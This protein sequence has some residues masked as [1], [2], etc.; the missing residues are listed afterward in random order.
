[1]GGS[2]FEVAVP[3]TPDVR[4]LVGRESECALLSDAL[5]H[6]VS[7][8]GSALLLRGQAGM[9]KTA[10][11]EWAVARA[12]VR[13]MRVLRM[14][15]APAEA[16]LA[17]A[18][19][20]QVLWPLL[21]GTTGLP[22]AQRDALERALGVREGAQ[23]DGFAV[24]DAT[25]GLLSRAAAHRPLLV[26]LDDLHCCDT[27][28]ATVFGSLQDRVTELPV[29]LLAATRPEGM[30]VEAAVGSDIVDVPRL[31]D[32]QA[33]LLVE[34]HRPGLEESAVE[35]ILCEAQGN[36]LALIELPRQLDRVSHRGLLPL[37]APLP[38]GE[39]L[40]DVFGSRINTLSRAARHLLLLTALGTESGHDHV[41]AGEPDPAADAAGDG[42]PQRE[43]VESGL[44]DTHPVTGRPRLRHPLIGS[45]AVH[46]APPS[47]VREAHL[48]LAGALPED[49][50]RHALHLAAGT[51]GADETVALRL[52][53]AAQAMA[54]R[55]GDIEAAR[56][57]ARAAALSEDPGAAATRRIM[58]AS[59][60][61][62]GSAAL[63]HLRHLMAEVARHPVPAELAPIHRF[64]I[65]FFQLHEGSDL[66]TPASLM[67]GILDGLDA[68]PR[69]EEAL[70]GL[71]DYLYCLLILVAVYTGDEDIWDALDRH[72]HL[73]SPLARLCHDVWKDPARTAHGAGDRLRDLLAGLTPEQEAQSVWLILWTAVGLNAV[74]EHP[75]VLERLGRQ[76]VWGTRAFVNLVTCRDDVLAGRWDNALRSA[77]RGARESVARGFELHEMTHHLHTG[78]ILAAR[79]DEAALDAL[80]ERLGPWARKR[81]LRFLTD[82]MHAH[83]SLLALGA[84]DYEEAYAHAA[85]VTPA[86]RLP[87]RVPWFQHA[88]LDLVQAAIHTGRHAQAR[89]HVDAAVAAEI[90]LISAHHSFVLAVARAV[91]SQDEACFRAALAHPGSDRWPMEKAR[92]HL[93]Y[94]AQLRRGGHRKAAAAPLLVA[95]RTFT[96]LGAALWAA[97]AARELRTVGHDPH[98][99]T[100]RPDAW[101]HLTAQERRIT[102]LAAAGLTNREIGNRLRL[103]PRTVGAHLYKAF[104][105]LGVTSRAALSHALRGGEDSG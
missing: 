66:R 95:H 68:A 31:T 17:Y 28:S 51:I 48:E 99:T 64:S 78:F 35:R 88:F 80:H 41:L 90:H 54:L 10:L 67:A 21:D 6:A 71:W 38:V 15:G 57:Y 74:G 25:L 14:A 26:V 69:P 11:L 91:E 24:G 105:K 2:G 101:H 36:P 32:E 5:D 62:R 37:G 46:L 86:G 63:E 59:L 58:A 39:R 19:L 93:A 3:G 1:M 34:A 102:E 82:G 60:A 13:R 18:A 98:R 42:H 100:P 7:G 70:A 96:A 8:T 84:Q 29:V 65:A 44:A 76:D 49:H 9:G 97:A 94:G 83:R 85:A 87:A 53:R 72:I 4:A 27:T 45:C 16:D 103:S 47:A 75:A 73:A 40:A 55:R 77:E 33:R 92:L 30:P 79:G 20:H 61:S 81:E 104:P 89:A 52:E 56:L 22:S 43:L 23:P 50:P 12:E